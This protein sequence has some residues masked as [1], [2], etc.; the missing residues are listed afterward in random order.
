MVQNRLQD[1]NWTNEYPGHIYASSYMHH[2]I[3]IIICI[4]IYIYIYMHHHHICIIIIY[5]SSYHSCLFKSLFRLTVRKS[6]KLCITV[7][8]GFPS[9]MASITGYVFISWLHH[10]PLPSRH[11]SERCKLTPK[12]LY[13]NAWI[14]TQHCDY[15]YPGA[16]GHQ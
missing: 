10:G 1:I 2:H 4:Y 7:A 5:A 12:Q 3:C 15:W 13:R 11:K 8:A 6:S 14:H 9:Q 16:P